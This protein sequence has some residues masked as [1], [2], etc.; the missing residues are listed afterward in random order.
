MS[1][2]QGDEPT[3]IDATPLE[4]FFFGS[5]D[6]EP[7]GDRPT[8]DETQV[9]DSSGAASGRA[10]PPATGEGG[11]PPA[12]SPGHRESSVPQD[13]WG[14]EP[15]HA[16]GPSRVMPARDDSTPRHD[17]HGGAPGMQRQAVP[18]PE[19]D[20]RGAVARGA[21]IVLLILASVVVGALLAYLALTQLR[22]DEPSGAGSS[23]GTAQE[24]GSSTQSPS[25]SPSS[26]ESSPAEASS[27]TSSSSSST[28]AER[29]GELPSG[30]TACGG[31]KDGIAV[32]RTTSVTSCPFAVAVRDAYLAADPGDDG[33]ATLEVRSPVTGRSYSMRCTGDVVTTCTGGN[34]ASVVLY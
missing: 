19:P 1:R 16:G 34:D 21:G 25:Q 22:G 30:A 18:P 32:G 17:D 7:T 9:V 20:R 10:Q 5:P 11:E 27:S 4:D 31:A 26:A 29:T 24:Q 12:S 6:D 14:E 8:A 13:W 23:E 3:P 2:Y 33:S 28:T 15:G